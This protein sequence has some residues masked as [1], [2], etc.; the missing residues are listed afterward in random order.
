MIRILSW[1]IWIWLYVSKAYKFQNWLQWWSLWIVS[2]VYLPAVVVRNVY[3]LLQHWIV[4]KIT[5]CMWLTI[6]LQRMGV[7]NH[8]WYLNLV[9]LLSF[10]DRK[11]HQ[12]T[13]GRGAADTP[14]ATTSTHLFRMPWQPHYCGCF[15]PTMC[16]CFR[17][18]HCHQYWIAKLQAPASK[19]RH[20]LFLTGPPLSKYFLMNP[21]IFTW[22]QLKH[23]T[24]LNG[25]KN[26]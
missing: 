21:S 19:W 22:W 16:P 7:I 11:A 14:S 9:S 6:V 4:M 18:L 25:K 8:I 10:N 13:K 5:W 24:S 26:L 15:Y 20:L 1:G 23:V 17:S 12:A 3:I 2:S